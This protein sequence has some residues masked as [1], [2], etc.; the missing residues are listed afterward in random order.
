MGKTSMTANLREKTQV[1]EALGEDLPLL[2]EINNAADP[3]VNSLTPEELVQLVGWSSFT[4]VAENEGHPVAFVLC[5]PPGLPYASANYRH[6]SRHFA[7][8]LYVDRI[9]VAEEARG[10]GIGR[11]LYE[12]MASR[13][14]GHWPCV[15]CEVNEHPPN[16][17]SMAFHHR[18]GFENL[19]RLDNPQSGK[20]VLF[21][22]LDL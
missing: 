13:A 8:F 18:L 16:P 9:A 7:E 19:D 15:L 20:T 22:K 17:A 11:M 12:E 14:R 10:F 2:L 5:L 3:G 1:R 4:L 6:L 21:M